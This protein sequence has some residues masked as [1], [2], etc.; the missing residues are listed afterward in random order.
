M[1]VSD[2]DE[3]KTELGRQNIQINECVF[4]LFLFSWLQNNNSLDVSGNVWNGNVASVLWWSLTTSMRNKNDIWG[5]IE[6]V[7]IM[8]THIV[9]RFSG[10]TTALRSY[11]D[12]TMQNLCSVKR[13]KR[14]KTTFCDKKKLFVSDVIRNFGLWP[15]L[16]SSVFSSLVWY[17]TLYRGISSFF[18]F[19][20][21]SSSQPEP[22]QQ[23]SSAVSCRLISEWKSALWEL[24]HP[25]RSSHNVFH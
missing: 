13:G 18:Q 5:S 8:Q 11:A 3:E 19:L 14:D 22:W 2:N 25:H 1:K 12:D 6:N 7:V 15:Y 24:L 16:L 21:S 9:T 10:V 4:W 23:P 17:E 20:L